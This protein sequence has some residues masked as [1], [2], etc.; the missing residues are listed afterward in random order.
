MRDRVYSFLGLANNNVMKG[1]FVVK[2]SQST[3]GLFFDTLAYYRLLK[4]L[5]FTRQL[6][7]LLELKTEVLSSPRGRL[8]QRIL[9]LIPVH[10]RHL[11]L[12]AEVR[13]KEIV[14]Y[15]PILPVTYASGY[16]IQGSLKSFR[17]KSL[18]NDEPENIHAFPLI[19]SNGFIGLTYTDI[20][21]SDLLYQIAH[22]SCGFVIRKSG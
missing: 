16:P 8:S 1:N 5:E 9:D 15:Q 6:H 11:S 3:V 10:H 7:E 12:S 14:I 2:Y 22:S 18:T 4:P 19:P 20:Q 21:Y 17:I 13:L